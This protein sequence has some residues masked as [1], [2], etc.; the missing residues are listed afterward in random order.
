MST[1]HSS[2]F[3]RHSSFDTPEK[4]IFI[5]IKE[6]GFIPVKST[7][8]VK[9]YGEHEMFHD[10]FETRLLLHALGNQMRHLA[11]Y[12]NEQMDD[13]RKHTAQRLRKTLENLTAM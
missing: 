4:I 5:L 2:L 9:G 10:R 13:E 3:V 6:A 8:I 11:Y 1:Q 7:K 12:T